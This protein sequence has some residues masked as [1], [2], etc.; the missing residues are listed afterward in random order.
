MEYFDSDPCARPVPMAAPLNRMGGGL[1]SGSEA[2]DSASLGVNIEARFTVGEYDI[3][4][5]SAKESNGLETW[6]KRNGYRFAR[7]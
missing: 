7:I 6:L 4:I 3:L 2:E 1:R 5:L